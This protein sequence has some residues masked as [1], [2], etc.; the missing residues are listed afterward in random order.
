MGCARRDTR[1]TRGYIRGG[2]GAAARELGGRDAEGSLALR[3][4]A[5]DMTGAARTLLR[6]GGASRGFGRGVKRG[7][8]SLLRLN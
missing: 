7:A 1:R 3:G 8:S 6:M 5:R 2:D 4:E